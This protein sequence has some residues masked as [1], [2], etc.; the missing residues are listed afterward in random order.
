MESFVQMSR[1]SFLTGAASAALA[2]LP[3][4]GCGNDSNKEEDE[5]IEKYVGVWEPTE[6]ILG[7]KP[8]DLSGDVFT[9]ELAQDMT[10]K[11]TTASGTQDITWEVRGGDPDKAV[12]SERVVL[13]I[14]S[15]FELG[16]LTAN[17][18]GTALYP[19]DAADTVTLDETVF[20]EA[21]GLDMRISLTG[22]LKKSS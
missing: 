3:L 9:V 18:P 5:R 1:R 7:D 17:L 21:D 20:S 13:K 22:T 12:L 10:G 6:L 16:G 19:T 11:L 15:D 14:D 4:V 8:L 2:A